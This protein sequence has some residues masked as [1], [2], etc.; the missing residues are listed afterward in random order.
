[1]V[2]AA[3]K[4]A[5]EEGSAIAAAAEIAAISLRL[6]PDSEFLALW[7]TD[8]VLAHRLK[9]PAPV[10][11][12][13]GAI[14]RAELRSALRHVEGDSPWLTALSLA[15]ARAAAA[16][17]DLYAE[18]VRRANRLLAA[19]PKLR[20]KDADRMLA[21]LLVEDAQPAT[22][23]KQASERSTRRLFERLLSLGAA[24][25]L[26]GRPTFRLYGL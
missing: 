16:A 3:I 20:G 4:L 5:K 18:L 23:G 2:G 17:S 19:G 21:I 26:T 24:R 6:R 25:E 22:A 11:L 13:A 7:L 1:M 8:A 12:I 15:Y 9:W 10:P 14:G